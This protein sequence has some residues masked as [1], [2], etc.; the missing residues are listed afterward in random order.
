MISVFGLK[1][2]R[3]TTTFELIKEILRCAPD[4]HPIDS[5][6]DFSQRQTTITINLRNQNHIL[7]VGYL[8]IDN[9]MTFHYLIYN[10]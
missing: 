4:Q 9:M 10:I 2:V 8:F 5:L 1:V 6:K 3:F 7:L